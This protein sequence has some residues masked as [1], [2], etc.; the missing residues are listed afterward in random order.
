MRRI[1]EGWWRLRSL[2]SRRDVERRLDEEMRFH[3]DQQIEKNRRAGL[4]EVEA[5]REAMRT[6]GGVESAK[7]RTRD[8]FRSLVL[9][10][11]WRDFRYGLRSLRRAPAFTLVSVLTLGLGIGATTGIFSIVNGILIKPLP[12][13]DADRLVDLR[14]LAPGATLPDKNVDMSATQFYTY[15][16]QGQTFTDIGLWTSS[17]AVVTGDGEAEQVQVVAVSDG[18]L[19]ALAVPPVLGRWFSADDL[20]PKAPDSLLVT[21]G[22]WQLRFGGDPG[23]VGRLV[24]VDG[25]PRRVIGVMP[26][27]FRFLD[28]APGLIAPLRFDRSALMLG[29]FNY[30]GIARLK[31][32]VTIAQANADIARMIPAW[33]RGWPPPPGVDPKI[34]ESA[35]F[36]ADLRPLKQLVVGNVGS[37]LWTLMAAIAVVLAIACAN[38]ANL[39]AVRAEDRQQEL[40]IR[41]ALGGGRARISRGLM[42]ESLTLGLL[43]G[44]LGLAIAAVGVEMLVAAGPSNL[45]RLR[46]IAIDFRVLGFAVAISIA[47]GFAFGLLPILR[48]DISHAAAELRGI[49]RTQTQHRGRRRVRSSLVIAQVALASV[50]LVASGLLIRSFVAMTRVDP[51]FANPGTGQLFTIGMP[52]S[53]VASDEQVFRI[54]TDIRDRIA[55]V[56]GVASASFANAVPLQGASAND[57]LLVEG[58]QPPPGQV[59]PIRRFR[60]IAPGYLRTLGTPLVAGQDFSWTDMEAG[61]PMAIVS[62]KLAREMW[63]STAAAIGK[64]IRENEASP[65]RDVIGVVADVYDDGVSRPAPASVYWPVMMDDFWRSPVHVLRYVTF[66]VRSDRAGSDGLTD[67]LRAAVRAVNGGLLMMQTRTLAELHDRSMAGPSFTLVMLALAAAMALTLSIVGIYGVLA[68]VVA[69]RTAEIGI[70]V[71][72]GAPR[73]DV[74]RMVLRDGLVLA[75][76]GTALGL[77]AA[78][79][80]ARWMASLLFGIGPLDPVTYAGVAIVLIAAALIASYVPAY[81]ATAVSPVEALRAR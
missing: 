3:L 54:Q 21:H 26:A 39:L 31:P 46:D 1:R 5:R 19:Q 73:T 77:A 69:Q 55:A 12:Y 61:R 56:P 13:A 75:V 52:A 2:G 67:D 80:F 28:L 20:D 53:L 41:A 4:S 42:I 48:L 58:Q 6:F 7:E 30:D 81:R 70:R 60:F 62:E 71:A 49:G 11:S 68:H 76:A 66:L 25:T 14:H 29:R 22:F 72:L 15:R 24:T 78:V 23:V 34:F 50:L 64:R 59:P 44:A 18:T 32:G 16:E 38:V 43:G 79:P 27:S 40:A 9:E 63:G 74:R 65:W 8:E 17:N 33:L 37:V 47:S 36:A 10:D 51:G 45:P 57:L 35:G